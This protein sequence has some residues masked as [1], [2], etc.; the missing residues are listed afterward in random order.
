MPKPTPPAIIPD[1]DPSTG[2]FAVF[3]IDKSSL[4]KIE[5]SLK[6]IE[7]LLERLITEVRGVN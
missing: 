3:E 7:V 6:R 5:E 4:S 2:A 1:Y